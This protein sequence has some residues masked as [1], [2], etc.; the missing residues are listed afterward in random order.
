MKQGGRGDAG[1]APASVGERGGFLSSAKERNRA[2][3]EHCLG[4]VE[5]EM[6]L[7]LRQTPPNG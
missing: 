1:A 3:D 6:K 2:T 4:V 5:S 7:P